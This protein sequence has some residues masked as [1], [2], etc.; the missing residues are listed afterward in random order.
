LLRGNGILPRMMWINSFTSLLRSEQKVNPTRP[1]R[2]FRLAS[3][4]EQTL[5]VSDMHL[6]Y[7][8][9]SGCIVVH[10][11][12][13]KRNDRTAFIT[14][15]QEQRSGDPLIRRWRTSSVRNRRTSP[16]RSSRRKKKIPRIIKKE[17][18]SIPPPATQSIYIASSK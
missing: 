14:H 2:R 5:V 11:V 10:I 15:P 16:S 4:L 18:R 8:I 12:A 17:Y 7:P 13:S 3:R 6:A 9:V 1:F